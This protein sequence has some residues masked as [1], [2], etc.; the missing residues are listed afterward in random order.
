MARTKKLCLLIGPISATKTD[1]RASAGWLRADVIEPTMAESLP[2]YDLR[3]ISEFDNVEEYFAD[4]ITAELVIA[5]LTTREP[6][7]LFELGIRHAT[8]LPTV[9]LAN[10]GDPDIAYFD[11]Q[12]SSVIKFRP[13][14][15]TTSTRRALANA[16]A[17][18][19]ATDV[20]SPTRPKQSRR[21]LANRLDTVASA[22]ADL[23]IN[24]LSEHVGE[25]QKISDEL[26][27][28]TDEDSPPSSAKSVALQTLP[29]LTNLFDALG[30]KQGAQ[31]VIAGAVGG[32]MSA[33][34]WPAVTTYALTLAVWQGKDAF[35][36]ALDRLLPKKNPAKARK[37]HAP[38][39][40]KSSVPRAKLSP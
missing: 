30:S 26:R 27:Q 1:Q 22:I 39:Q 9:Y 19:V 11:F 8:S 31:V 20:Y 40:R 37:P 35:M 18:A 21:E 33:G 25:L 14:T 29:I 38:T 23:R 4:L 3:R 2:E 24:S 28:Q 36:L 32:I 34:G 10:E 15:E 7:I 12:V 17:K 13:H 16:I 5:D 6:S